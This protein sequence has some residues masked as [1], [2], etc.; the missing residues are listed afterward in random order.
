VIVSDWNSSIETILHSDVSELRERAIEHEELVRALQSGEVDAVVVL[1][2]DGTTISR[3]QSDEPLYRTL[4]EALPQG[5]ATVLSDGTIVYLNRHLAALI[6]AETDTL[7]GQNLLNCVAGSDR[8]RCAAMLK[9][10]LTTPQESGLTFCWAAGEA[11][12]L[13]SAIRLPISGAEAVGL[14][15]VDVRDQVALRAAEEASRAKDELL[16]S[17]SHELRTPLTSIMGWIQLLELEL[18]GEARTQHAV[19]HLK[20]AVLA[21]TKIV[22]DLLDLARSEK[23]SLPVVRTECDLG[24]AVRMAASFVEMQAQKKSVSLKIDLPERPLTVRADPDRLRQVFLNLLSNAVKFTAEGEVSI[25]GRNQDGFVIVDVTDSGIGITPEFLP[26]VFEP[27]RRSPRAEGYPGLGIGMAISRRIVEAHSGTIDVASE[28]P[29]H[30]A[31]FTVRLPQ[32]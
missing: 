8:P 24:E 17:V 28:G 9:R 29:G 2:K 26:L 23:G 12:A 32:A 20:N 11:P 7:L 15:I 22:D 18:A 1:E 31:T 19:Q 25:R 16:A 13:V 21:E 4:I 3:L 30:G 27:F 14:V 6:G 10:A 5:V